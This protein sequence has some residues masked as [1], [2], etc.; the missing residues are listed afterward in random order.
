MSRNTNSLPKSA[1]TASLLLIFLSTTSTLAQTSQNGFPFIQ[2]FAKSV[3]RAGTQNWDI[4]EDERGF[5][6]FANNDGLLSLEGSR[7]ATY[8]LPNFTLMRSLA[9]R[10]EGLIYVG[11]QDEMGYFQRNPK[12]EWVYRSLV[13]LIPESY[14]SFEDIWEIFITDQGT[15]F[16]SQKVIFRLTQDNIQTIEPP[17]RFDNFFF[18]ENKLY[19]RDTREG[20]LEL[21]GTRINTLPGGKRFDKDHIIRSILP[22]PDGGLLIFT[23]NEGLYLMKKDGIVPFPVAADD[24]LKQY[25]VY[26]ATPLAD[27]NFAVGSTTNGL[28]LMSGDGTILNHLNKQNGLQNNTVL[29]IFRDSRD[30]L[31]LG[32]D[33]GIDYIQLESPF[34][35]LGPASGIDGTGYAAVFHQN[36][37]ILGT[38]QGLFERNQNKNRG[39]EFQKIPG[40]NGQ[41]WCLDS[42]N[43]RLLI[44]HH[45]GLFS[46]EKGQITKISPDAGVWKLIRLSSNPDYLIAGTYTGLSLY[47]FSESNQNWEFIKQLEGFDESARVLEEDKDGNIWVS[48]VYKGLYKI[49]LDL[50]NFEISSV[51]FYNSGDG[52]PDDLRI[53]VGKIREEVVFATPKGI[54]RYETASDSFLA[55]ESFTEI[56]GADVV[57]DRILEDGEKNIWFSTSEAFGMIQ[58]EGF[59]LKQEINTTYFNHLKNKLVEKFEYIYTLSE[60]ES[61]IG[62]QFGFIRYNGKQPP[63]SAGDFKTYLTDIR[64]LKSPDT[65]IYALAPEPSEGNK[66]IIKFKPNENSFSFGF[67]SPFNEDVQEVQY[68]YR[69]EGYENTWSDWSYQT[70]KE[71]TN[72]PHGSYTFYAQ[73]KNTYNQLSNEAT[74]SFQIRTPWYATNAFKTGLGIC[75]LLFLWVL[76]GH[77]NRKIEKEKKELKIKQAQRIQEKEA[78]FQQEFKKTEAEIIKLTNE[79]LEADV[80]HKSR[81]LASATMHLMQKA[82]MMNKLRE[83]LKKLQQIVA[84]ENSKKIQQLVR[85]IEMDL[86]LDEEWEQFELHFDQVHENFLKKLREKYPN[87]T[88]KDQKLC[89]YLRMNLSTKEIAPL[90]KIS[91]RGVEISRYR[92]RKKLDLDPDTNL[93]DFMIKL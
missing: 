68:R 59:G 46:F 85:N 19:I 81:E 20:L 86:Q 28:L 38:N 48:H 39:L 58:I 13:P 78:A 4:A 1:L 73:A 26:C 49:S 54:Y 37:L 80:R 93:I 22:H 12:G 31:W 87:L 71:Y 61:Y 40:L 67:L 21:E 41:V 70:E 34:T 44:G 23:L 29:S 45:N 84:P 57:V 36:K 30:N 53:N 17:E 33:N 18:P 56:I 79:K 82:E 10:D 6:Y 35:T 83:D 47:H 65:L 77:Y 11:G 91:I 25:E 52:L 75:G 27:G 32:L 63:F 7:W 66:Q 15:Y 72:L 74:W 42:H 64:H 51:K 8:P 24:F 92:L 2:S 76:R 90:M 16:C 50:Q 62:T 14:R 9:I 55:H 69:L 5:T 88:P 3:Y 89:A 60:Q 43:E